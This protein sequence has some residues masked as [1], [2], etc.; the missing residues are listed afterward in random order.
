MLKSEVRSAIFE[1]VATKVKPLGFKSQKKDHMFTR[2]FDGGFH[3]ICFAIVDYSPK[4]IVTP[5]VSTRLDSL[6]EI[7]N[8]FDTTISPEGRSTQTAVLLRPDYFPGRQKRFSISTE[9][10]L[11]EKTAEILDVL[12]KQML[13]FME[14]CVDISF[15]ESVL[16]SESGSKLQPNP[17][18]LALA[19]IGAAYL[20][21]RQDIAEIG[22][23]ARAPLESR[24]ISWELPIFDQT[25]RHILSMQAQ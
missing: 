3:R 21:G 24:T 18:G 15:V 1:A 10:E 11:A 16:N 4:I 22:A 19:I 2:E 17:L 9:E 7:A 13:P 6:D 5:M 20:C 8:K 12:E 25:L 23:K 14:R